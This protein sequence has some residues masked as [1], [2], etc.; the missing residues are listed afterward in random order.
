MMNAWVYY[1][2]THN[3]SNINHAAFVWFEN[4]CPKIGEY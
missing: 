3:N 2:D 1:C 4:I